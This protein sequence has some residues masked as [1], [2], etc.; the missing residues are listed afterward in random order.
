MTTKLNKTIYGKMVLQAE[1]ARELGLTKLANDVFDAV[2]VMPREETIVYN[3]IDLRSDIDVALWKIATDVIAYH[4]LGSVD[5]QAIE[6]VVGELSEKVIAEIE[7]KLGV[8]GKIG[9]LEEKVFGEKVF[10]EK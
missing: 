2:G 5:I 3:E 9:A 8:G 4:D 6:E 1:E 10:G 7:D